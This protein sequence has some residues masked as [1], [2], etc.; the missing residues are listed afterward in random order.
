MNGQLTL[1]RRQLGVVPAAV[2]LLTIIWT[3][4]VL[5]WVKSNLVADDVE[6]LA[7]AYVLPTIV[8]AI[9]FGSTPAVASSFVSALAAAYFIYPPGFTFYIA[10]PQHVAKLGFIVLL[11]LT[12]SKAV[13]AITEDRTPKAYEGI[14]PPLRSSRWRRETCRAA[15]PGGHES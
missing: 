3:T 8:I 9:F 11:S 2:S 15:G 10:D 13:A 4:I 5:T 7:L 14:R 1:Y 12:A 6:D